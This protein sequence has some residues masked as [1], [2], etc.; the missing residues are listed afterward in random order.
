M[1]S[2]PYVLQTP[3]IIDGNNYLIGYNEV[4]M[5]EFAESLGVTKSRVNKWENKGV[6][7][8]SGLLI[9]IA[10]NTILLFM[11]FWGVRRSLQKTKFFIPISFDFR[12]QS[13]GKSRENA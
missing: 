11:C 10:Q 1:L 2:H 9:L 12:R 5:S 3:I 6:I 4:S 7:P 8:R 13:V